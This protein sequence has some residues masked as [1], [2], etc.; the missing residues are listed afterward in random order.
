MANTKNGLQKA[1]GQIEESNWLD[2]AVE[3]RTNLDWLRYSK[4]IALEVVDFL[5][6]N[7]ISQ[8]A[9][10]QNMD[11]SPQMVSKWLKGSEN[12]TIETIAKIERVLSINL[13][14]IR[15]VAESRNESRDESTLLEIHEQKMVFSKSWV[16]KVAFSKV[17]NSDQQ[18]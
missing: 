14:T 6:K 5:H 12:F 15:T 16:A 9:F 2:K 4:R 11:V 1:F 18:P 3:W 17:I 13:I 8:K 7:D 10:A